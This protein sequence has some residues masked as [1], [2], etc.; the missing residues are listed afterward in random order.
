[1]TKEE[2]QKLYFRYL[3]M[4]DIKLAKSLAEL[5]HK[6]YAVGDIEIYTEHRIAARVQLERNRSGESLLFHMKEFQIKKSC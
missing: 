4:D 1:M 5:Y 3:R 6:R 2:Y